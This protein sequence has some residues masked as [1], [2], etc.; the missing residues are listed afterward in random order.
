[1]VTRPLEMMTV[2]R[3]GADKWVEEGV[4]ATSFRLIRDPESRWPK[5]EICV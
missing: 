1:V 4:Q 2:L 3:F 5:V